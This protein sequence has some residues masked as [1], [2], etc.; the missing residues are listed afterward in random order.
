LRDCRSVLKYC[1]V[2]VLAMLLVAGTLVLSGPE[3]GSPGAGFRLWLQQHGLA[4]PEPGVVMVL[5]LSGLAGQDSPGG[6]A[7]WT[8]LLR[9]GVEQGD[10]LSSDSFLVRVPQS[11]LAAA[12]A[13]AGPVLKTYN[14]GNRLAQSLS[15][16]DS[17]PDRSAS[18]A[19]NVTVFGPEDKTAVVQAVQSL[20]GSVLRGETESGRVLRLQIPRT[21]LGSISQL[22]A[23]VYIEPAESYRLMNDRARDL[24]AATPLGADGWL[25]PSQQG[26]TGAGQIIG[27]A[28]SGLDKGS[29][30]D[31]HPDLASLPGHMPKVVMLKSWAGAPSVADPNGHGTHMAATIAGTGAASS[32]RYQGLAPGAS[33]YF[34]G[35][36]NSS[37]QLDPPP[38]L[39]AL[40]SP[41]YAAGVR[42]HVNGW[43]GEGS[44]YLSAAS[45]TDQFIR[46]HPDFLAI[47]SAGN[48]GPGAGTLTPE[49]YTKNGLVIGASQSPHPVFNPQQ[50]NEGQAFD[51][52][53]HGPTSDGRMKPELLAPGALISAR[54]S[55]VASEFNLDNGYYTYMEGTSMAAAVAGG[56]AAMLREY[57][58]HYEQAL[59]PSAA[60]LKAALINGANPPAA[61]PS[62]DGFGVLDLGS[63]ILSLHEKAFKFVDDLKGAAGGETVTYT[64]Q[65]SAAGSPF[66][67]TL[68]WT[69]PAVAAGASHPLV[70]NLDLIVQDPTG[71]VWQ[72]NSFLSDGKPDDTNNVE[73]VYIAKPEL[74]TYTILVKGTS[75]AQNTVP[76]S[77]RKVQD[78][79]LVYGQPL[80]RDVVQ[81]VS[82]TVTLA[83]G[84]E[85]NLSQARI[86][87]ER[88]GQT[89]AWPAAGNA[90]V[91]NSQ[92]QTVNNQL[93]GMD[94]YLSPD[95]TGSPGYAYLAGRTWQA[96]G[97]QL[98][99]VGSNILLTE[100]NPDSRS[101]GFFLTS[102][103]SDQLLVNGSTLKDPGILP[104][105][106]EIRATINPST[107]KIWQ[108]AV[109]FNE[110]SGFL[111]RIDLSKRELFL[112]GNRQPLSLAP[113]AAL[114][115][116]DQIA[117]ADRAD[118]PFGA[119]ASPAWDKLLPGLSV[120]LMLAPG[121]GE[122]MYV[123]ARRRLAVGTITG[124]DPAARTLTLSSGHSYRV[125]PGIS[126]QLDEK[127]VDFT[128][129]SPGQH[130]IMMLF[131]E[132]QEILTLSAYS[133]VLYGR[134]VYANTKQ[135]LLYMIDDSNNFHILN[136]SHD[137]Q[138]F[139]WGLPASVNAV[140][141]GS[142][143]RLYLDPGTDQVWRL[144]LAEVTPETTATVNSYDPQQQRLMTD[145]GTYLLTD[146]TLVTKNSYPVDPQDLASGEEIIMAPLLA[147]EGAQPLLAAVAAQTRPAVK[148]PRLD[149]AVPWRDKFIEL[150]GITSADR[151]YLYLPGKGRQTIPV[152]EQGHFSYQFQLGADLMPNV[153]SGTK[154]SSKPELIVQ[155]VAVDTHTG[156]VTGQFVTIPSQVSVKL[157]DMTGHWAEEDVQ[158][159]A[160]QHLVSGYPDGTFRPEAAVTRAEF[161][162]L[163]TGAL[164][165]SGDSGQI[166]F[167][168]AQDIPTWARQAV[169]CGVQYGLIHGD[170]KGC[171]NPNQL[172]TRAE[173]AVLL[174]RALQIFAPGAVSVLTNQTL[175]FDDWPEV[176]SWARP[177]VESVLNAKL[178][179]GRASQLF[180]PAAPLKRG[181][182]AAVINHF[183]NYIRQAS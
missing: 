60:L 41:A 146:R 18:L 171:F 66:K 28:D 44:G 144:D 135:Q 172:I 98:I 48:N 51:F 90:G 154:Q 107:Q 173:S 152:I 129:L 61:G 80:V 127:E 37:G 49:A 35:L 96:E 123:G 69:D 33:I 59:R 25:S 42:I 27:L 76:G 120:R 43:G 115:Y 181:E 153:D 161:T 112:L 183:L 67:A 62:S 30:E 4:S 64:D 167:V 169:A 46:E 119:G 32:G 6:D 139:R 31:I 11:K 10:L 36:T 14:P 121:S 57:F 82:S 176:P 122:I 34:Q 101:G 91:G 166:K 40:F 182:A 145:E 158:T 88:D 142:W 23:V 15:G 95:T 2:L 13:I 12:R 68:A 133:Q 163:L 79:A 113:Q 86:S 89:V 52:S 136:F 93:A 132:T 105:G 16:A 162:V 137:S 50:V 85:V 143:A 100:I 149:V 130:A 174:D 165:W 180:V 102:E 73:Q 21:S 141:P 29:I 151:L 20:G 99:E 77:S 87:C 8:S 126:L 168:D 55:Q 45:Q 150:S 75:I 125:G 117:D 19:V 103:A 58:Q 53:S 138:V 78:F 104:P 56:A 108:A 164:G 147:S 178:F 177:S 74:G 5:Q 159:L 22:P 157:S 170:L 81:S 38:D 148:V 83:S 3:S 134:V 140:E 155:L 179:V 124:V 84:A 97:V 17:G 24:V 110:T 109:V 160:A 175:S 72:G 106:G 94:I 114:A 131:P 26:L 9:L 116:L 47:F 65:V 7:V 63:T 1:A 39:T 70:N 54:A 156:G 128:A 111:D 118:S 92:G 71:K